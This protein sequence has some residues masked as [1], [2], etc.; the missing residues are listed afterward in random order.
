MK[1]G[2]PQWQQLKPRERIRLF[3]LAGLWLL[4]AVY[5]VFYRPQ[6]HRLRQVRGEYE[7]LHQQ[8]SVLKS[9]LPNLDQERNEIDRQTQENL[10]FERELKSV[11]N[12]LVR[13]A[14]LGR[15]L[16]ELTRQGEGLDIEFRSIKQNIRDDAELPQA[17]LEIAL[18]ASYQD[19]VTYLHRVERLSSYLRVSDLEVTEPKEGQGPRTV[20]SARLVLT[21]PLRRSGDPARLEALE[22]ME[23]G[24]VPLSRSPFVSS[25]RPADLQ[26]L[27][28]VKVT[29]VTLRGSASTA[30]INDQ[31]VHEGQQVDQWTVRKILA[32]TV[33]LSDGSESYAVSMDSSGS[34]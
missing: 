34:K 21:T 2:F 31:V 33:V 15:L 5:Q 8:W 18:T 1:G 7:S 4:F 11:E 16:G 3:F 30:I 24:K 17:A 9:S 6:A 26:R 25:A 14:D 13:P 27:K 28:S 32:G 29:G 23:R 20:G 10:L 22:Q 12:R 19:L